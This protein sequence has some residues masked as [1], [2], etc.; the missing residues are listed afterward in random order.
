MDFI[1][2]IIGISLGFAAG[3]FIYK[4]KTA[5][6]S[7][8]LEERINTLKSDL[9]KKEDELNSERD[10][11]LKISNDLA[12]L[13]AEYKN[14][15]KKLTDEGTEFKNIVN[16]IL[17]EKSKEFTDQNK[18]KLNE[19]LTPLKEKIKDFEIK[20]TQT[21][22]DEVKQRASLVEQI[23]F[24]T[25]Q[26]QQMSK[27]AKD[28]TSALKGETKTQG[29]WG[30]FILES[31]LEKSGLVKDREYSVQESFTTEKGNRLQP[32]VIIN[33]PDK[34]TI[35]ID[36]KVS[37]NA[38]EKYSSTDDEDEK[39]R[40]IKEH[41]ISIK[42]HIKELSEKNYQNIYQLKSLDFVLMFLPIEPAFGL[43]IQAEQNLFI[44]AYEKNIILVSPSTLLATL[45]TIAN[46]W[47]QAYQNKNAVEIARQSGALYDKFQGLLKDLQNVGE[48][49]NATQ[50]SYDSAIKKLHTGK[51]NLV[52]S[53]EKIKKLGAKT[54]K[55]LPSSFDNLI[56]EE[57]NE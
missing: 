52:T 38:Y 50:T 51:G 2:L 21:H 40:A 12:S 5:G 45:R 56:D 36:S 44:S 3:Y 33:L 11:F 37:L 46:I 27:D 9:E 16:E 6:K 25:E 24:L 42:K 32:D 30:E 8:V 15:E 19:I 31:I 28:L 10:E 14:L 35:V 41:L 48:K 34:K 20:I 29:N 23:K 53:V 13:K 55:S 57:S 17:K 49:L 4:Y 39:Q 22:V 7:S 43:A 18:T 54:T 47:R 1:Y 26:N